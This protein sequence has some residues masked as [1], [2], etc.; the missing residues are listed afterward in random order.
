MV[1][2]LNYV[3][4]DIVKMYIDIAYEGAPLDRYVS[5]NPTKSEQATFCSAALNK[6]VPLL[7]S[8]SSYGH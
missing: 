7:L 8:G 3:A 2:K 4:L 1:Q 6:V 5:L